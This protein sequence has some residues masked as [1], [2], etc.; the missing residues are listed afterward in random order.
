MFTLLVEPMSQLNHPQVR[1]KWNITGSQG[2]WSHYTMNSDEVVRASF[3]LF[4]GVTSVPYHYGEES[5]FF[6]KAKF[7]NPVLNSLNQ[8][9]QQL[10]VKKIENAPW[11]EIEATLH[12]I[13]LQMNLPANPID[14]SFGEELYI[15]F[16]TQG[17]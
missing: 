10:T 1:E 2:K 12:A 8:L 6:N 15:P 3:D 5:N 14:R 4:K 16:P 17:M 11:E 13:A 7:K 9:R